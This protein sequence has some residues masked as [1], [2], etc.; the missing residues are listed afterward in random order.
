[1]NSH[2]RSCFVTGTDTEV[3]KTLISC[4]L[5]HAMCSA[6]VRA[7]GMKPVAAG[8]ALRAGVWCNEDVEQLQAAGIGLP[9]EVAVPYLLRTAAAP[10]IA[11][12][13]DGVEI[14]LVHIRHCYRRAAAAADAVVVEGVGGFRVPL[15]ARHDTAG[16]ARM[17]ALPVV[18]VVGLRLGCLNHALL[19]ADAVA[20]QGLHLAGWVANGIDPAMHYTEDNVAALA[21]RIGAPLLGSVPWMPTPSVERAAAHLDLAMLQFRGTTTSDAIE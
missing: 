18:L 21:E 3:G 2:F 1:M 4:A 19:T 6:G 12:A 9:T 17:L 15:N 14:D 20:A 8:A 5:L 7:A 13:I 11:A 16:L 10:H